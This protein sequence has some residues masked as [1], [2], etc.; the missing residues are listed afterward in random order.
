VLKWILV[1]LFTSCCAGKPYRYT[2][3]VVNFQYA[4]SVRLIVFCLDGPKLG[5]GVIISKRQVLTA[6]HVA[7]CKVGPPPFLIIARDVRSNKIEMKIDRVSETVD[8]ARL[9]TLNGAEQFPIYA[10]IN[11]D[12]DAKV[13]DQVCVVAGDDAVFM[14][15][16]CG[17][18][19]L[20]SSTGYMTTVPVVPGNSGS[21]LWN[22]VGQVIGII[23]RGRWDAGA[24]H[25]GVAVPVSE[26]KNDM[27]DDIYVLSGF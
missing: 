19:T 17:E 20:P 11:L 16:K 8:V 3:S 5:S 6:K 23:V 13:G 26:F 25:V 14:I 7:K 15:R 24:E 27:L 18:M 1:L 9:I 21:A 10:S 4:T 12:D 22:D 2:P